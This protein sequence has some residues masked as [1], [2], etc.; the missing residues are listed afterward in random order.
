MAKIKKRTSGGGFLPFFL[1]LLITIILTVGGGLLGAPWVGIL[2]WPF[3]Y[4]A[5]SIGVRQDMEERFSDSRRDAI[6][7]EAFRQGNTEVKT[8]AHAWSDA[9]IPLP[10]SM[11][12]RYKKK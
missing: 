3:F 8:K 10:M 11:T 7:S 12:T 6:A 2:T 5:I 1:S 4:I 9:P